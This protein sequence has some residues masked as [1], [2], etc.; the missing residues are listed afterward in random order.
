[1]TDNLP[2]APTKFN[3]EM[4]KKAKEIML[5]YQSPEPIV[6]VMPDWVMDNTEY[7][8]AAHQVASSICD[9]THDYII[10]RNKRIGETDE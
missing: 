9:G 5:S 2:D 4:L 3:L 1:M 6:F 7:L 10:V 8:K